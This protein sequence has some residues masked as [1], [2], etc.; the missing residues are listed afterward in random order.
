VAHASALVTV[1]DEILGGFITDTN[2]AHAA[3]ALF[4]AGYPVVH[5]EVVPDQPD[6]IAAAIRRAVD[7]GEADRILVCGGVGPTP[8]DRTHEGVASALGRELVDDQA[9]MA[10]IQAI[11]DRMHAAGWVETAEISA[12]NRRMGRIAAGG[13]VL[14]N[15]RGMAPPLGYD[16]GGDRWLFVLPGV[17]REFTAVL[18]EAVIPAYCAGGRAAVVRELRYAQA[19]EAEFT[20]AMETLA[21]EFPG[22]S[23]GSYP[24][25]A[26]RELLLRLRG[27]SGTEVDAAAARLLE[28]RPGAVSGPG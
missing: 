4:E 26:T 3:R 11:V 12:A 15:R 10:H 13:K 9:A 21:A 24:Q 16:L 1:G 6:R 7:E 28:L 25:S 27:A 17:P 19:V 23:V 18:E 5:I 8:D 20:P 14:E 2:S 22:V